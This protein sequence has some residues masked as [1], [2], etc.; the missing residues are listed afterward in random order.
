MCVLFYIPCI[1]CRWLGELPMQ[2]HQ[3]QTDI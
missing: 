2:V 1:V 3:V